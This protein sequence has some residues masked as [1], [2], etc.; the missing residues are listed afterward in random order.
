MNGDEHVALL[1]WDEPYEGPC[2]ICAHEL[3]APDLHDVRTCPTCLVR[4]HA[5]HVTCVVDR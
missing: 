2:P 5:T 4:V 3:S 1:Q